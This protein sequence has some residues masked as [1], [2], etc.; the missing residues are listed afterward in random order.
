MFTLPQTSTAKE[1]SALAG[2]PRLL[3]A[4]TNS[5]PCIVPTAAQGALR[6][7]HPRRRLLHHR[8]VQTL[9]SPQEQRTAR[10]SDTSHRPNLSAPAAPMLRAHASSMADTLPLPPSPLFTPL[11]PALEC[12]HISHRTDFILSTATTDHSSHRRAAHPTA[13]P[14]LLFSV[15]FV[16][17][18]FPCMASLI[19]WGDKTSPSHWS[20]MSGTVRHPQP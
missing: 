9:V 12:T 15:L 2:L 13:S 4:L 6:C 3:L 19:A 18:V 11:L 20:W 1:A 8:R 10:Y 14:L 5:R 7:H 16:V 17:A